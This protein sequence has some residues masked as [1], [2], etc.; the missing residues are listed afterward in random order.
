MLTVRLGVTGLRT[1]AN[2]TL[3]VISSSWPGDPVDS[4]TCR[5]RLVH[6]QGPRSHTRFTQVSSLFPDAIK[7][8]QKVLALLAVLG[9]VF[10]ALEGLLSATQRTVSGLIW[11]NE[12][13]A[14]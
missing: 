12:R 4:T 10:M 9:C 5:T 13:G 11:T 14:V 6:H 3:S 7:T 8:Q 2:L 1:G